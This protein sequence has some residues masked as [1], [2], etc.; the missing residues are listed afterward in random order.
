MKPAVNPDSTELT[1][2]IV[3][4][5]PHCAIRR[6]LRL[7]SGVTAGHAMGVAA[8]DPAFAD[9]DLKN[10]TYGIFGRIARGDE[11]LQNGDRLEIYRPL[12]ADPKNA[13]R[14]RVKQARK[15]RR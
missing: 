9:I 3:L 7:D 6:Q 13:R 12:A 4:A 5:L 15:K 14:E 11:T 8:L 10:C 1:V 2:E